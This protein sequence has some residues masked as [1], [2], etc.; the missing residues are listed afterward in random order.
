MVPNTKIR[1]HPKVRQYRSNH[2]FFRTFHSHH[3][4]FLL[5]PCTPTLLSYYGIFTQN[6]NL[7]LGS[8]GNSTRPSIVTGTDKQYWYTDTVLCNVNSFCFWLGITPQTLL[9]LWSLT[10][11]NT[12]AYFF[13]VVILML[14]Y[15]QGDTFF[16]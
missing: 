3:L 1:P 2:I 4:S 9:L 10:T 13:C 11:T 14:S 5:F 7:F 12:C 16:W 6:H 15:K 8:L